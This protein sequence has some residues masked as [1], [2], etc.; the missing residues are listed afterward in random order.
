MTFKKIWDRVRYRNNK[1][2]YARKIGVRLGERCALLFD[3]F[4]GFGTEPWLVTLGDHVEITRGVLFITHDGGVWSLRDQHP[5]IDVF[6]PIII[7]N[8]VFIGVNSIILPR[9]TIGDNV[10]IGAG[11]VV[12]RDIGANSVAAG[13]PAKVI[14]SLNE[15]EQGILLKSM[16]TKHMSNEEKRCY[17]QK[18]RPDWFS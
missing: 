13:V 5:D 14:R 9:V 4:N 10:V 3:V 8:N 7:G 12:T 6:G 16:P 18:E 2:A 17:L 11:S 15:Y 1:T